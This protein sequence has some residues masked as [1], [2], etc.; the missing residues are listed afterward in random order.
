MK[1]ASLILLLTFTL[2][3]P[4]FAFQTNASESPTATDESQEVKSSWVKVAPSSARASI[5]M[6]IKPRFVQRKFTPVKG[7]PEITVNLHIAT[8]KGRATTLVFGYNDLAV[9]PKTRADVDKVLDG[10]VRGM[11]TNVLGQLSDENPVQA[12][13]SR[14]GNHEGRQFVFACINSDQEFV[15]MSRIFVVEDRQYQITAIMGATVFDE[16]YAA[17]F[18]NSFRLEKP[19]AETTEDGKEASDQANDDAGKTDGSN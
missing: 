2:A 14:R 6:P 16:S 12:I 19:K 7:Q 15:C 11:V 4:L 13:K 3:A 5:E 8:L 18:L 17:R 1:I 9:K 10:A